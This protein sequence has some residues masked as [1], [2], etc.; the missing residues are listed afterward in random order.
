MN[1][2]TFEE[3]ILLSANLGNDADTTAAICGQ[4]A[5]AHYGFSQIPEKWRTKVAM[6]KDIEQL[7][8]D[9]CE[10]GAGKI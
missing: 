2:S 4:I 1:S 10:V 3:G 8:I 7:A 5:G 6:S 9:L